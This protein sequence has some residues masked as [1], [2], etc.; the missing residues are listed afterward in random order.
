MSEVQIKLIETK[1]LEG[2]NKLDPGKA[3]LPHITKN[4]KSFPSQTTG[5]IKN[6]LLLRPKTRYAF[7]PLPHITERQ[8]NVTYTPALLEALESRG[9]LGEFRARVRS[10]VF[11]AL[12]D[13]VRT[14]VVVVHLK[15]HMGPLLTRMTVLK[16]FLR[17]VQAQLHQRKPSS[18]T[19]S[20]VNIWTRMGT[21]IRCLFSKRVRP[22]IHHFCKE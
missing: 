16:R 7:H 9:T 2:E 15:N 10:E 6:G 4:H 8:I 19:N 5:H 1:P 18:P 21:C 13:E 11:R 20:S 14:T 17:I 22:S 3:S 12:E